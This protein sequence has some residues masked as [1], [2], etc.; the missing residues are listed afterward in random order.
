MMG[1]LFPGNLPRKCEKI[2][3]EKKRSTISKSAGMEADRKS[4]LMRTCCVFF[5]CGRV[6]IKLKSF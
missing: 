5:K 3:G 1:V 6:M 2:S 4:P